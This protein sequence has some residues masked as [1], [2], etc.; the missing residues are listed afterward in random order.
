MWPWVWQWFLR[1]G[2]K[3][4]ISLEFWYLSFFPEYFFSVDHFKILYWICYNTVSILFWFFGWKVCEILD[5]QLG[6]KPVPPSLEGEVLTNWT[7]R[8]VP[9]YLICGLSQKL[10]LCERQCHRMKSDRLGENICKSHI[11]LDKDKRLYP[12]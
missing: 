3:S 1:H 9:K 10:L 6:I 2:T 11:T 8:E 5:P 12:I 7:A 4:I